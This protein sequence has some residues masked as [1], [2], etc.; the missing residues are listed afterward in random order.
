MIGGR[1]AEVVSR[2]SA[3]WR[4]T[5]VHN[6]KWLSIGELSGNRKPLSSASNSGVAGPSVVASD[7]AVADAQT[8][9]SVEGTHGNCEQGFRLGL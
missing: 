9:S 4:L 3:F 2:L 7:A 8:T 5:P 6:A 1:D